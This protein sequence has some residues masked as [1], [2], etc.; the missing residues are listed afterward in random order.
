M[1]NAGTDI[2]TSREAA[3]LA[4]EHK[5]VYFSPGI[6]PLSAGKTGP[7]ELSEIR[8][9]AAS[10][11]A[12]ALGETGLDFTRGEISRRAQKQ[13]FRE[14]ILIA[15]ETGLPLVIH[16]RNASDEVFNILSDEF[17]GSEP[18][19]NG[20]MHC[21]SGSSEFA[22]E[23][24]KLNFFISFAGNITYPGSGA[25]RKAAAGIPAERMLFETDAP[26]LA[27]QQ[28]RGRKNEPVFIIHTARCL[29]ET[30]GKSD[31]EFISGAFCRASFVFLGRGADN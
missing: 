3:R 1:V 26:F 16:N 24:I 22:A 14:T 19:P 18:K 4:R 31:E 5:Q 20:I 13:L 27:P 9:L 15:K 28:A 10:E 23:C 11:K 7:G 29:A 2:S 6:H 21:F 25:L 17:T 30:A 8:K 12:C